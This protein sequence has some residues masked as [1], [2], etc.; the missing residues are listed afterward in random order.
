VE[1]KSFWNAS[2]PGRFSLSDH[3]PWP[4]CCTFV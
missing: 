1:E 4:L 3:V 2:C